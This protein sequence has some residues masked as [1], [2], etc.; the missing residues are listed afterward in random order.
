MKIVTV[1]APLCAPSRQ[2]VAW[3]IQHQLDRYKFRLG[4]IDAEQVCADKIPMYWY[5]RV[6]FTDDAATWGEYVLARHGYEIIGPWLEPRNKEWAA[7]YLQCRPE[8]GPWHGR[9]CRKG[10][11]TGDMGGLANPPP[12][13]QDRPKREWWRDAKPSVKTRRRRSPR[14]RGWR[15]WFGF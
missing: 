14:K 8:K 3:N 11:S 15:N 9:E 4:G 5:V 10:R 6:R 12:A 7:P 2:A 13:W 1:A